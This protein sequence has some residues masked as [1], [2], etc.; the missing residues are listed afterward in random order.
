MSRFTH[1]GISTYGTSENG[2]WVIE[3]G[4]ID[5][6]PP[7][8]DGAPLFAGHYTVFDGLCKFNINVDMNNITDFG[9]GQYYIKLPFPIHDNILF[10]DG[11]LHD[12]SG[13]SQYAILGH[14]NKGSDIVTLL[15]IASNGRH[16]PFE[17]NTPVTLA[18]EDNFHISGIYEIDH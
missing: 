5:G 10:S 6:T 4:T 18:Q 1:P 17:H 9:S 13:G 16:V 12:Y 11:C 7:V 15:S 2:S 8:F 3:G 14:V